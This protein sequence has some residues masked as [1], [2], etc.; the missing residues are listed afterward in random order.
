MTP[1]YAVLR[2]TEEFYQAQRLKTN[3]LIC[4]G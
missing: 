4:L 2:L 3:T 1:V